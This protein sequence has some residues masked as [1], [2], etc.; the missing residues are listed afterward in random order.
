MSGSRMIRCATLA[1]LV[2]AAGGACAQSGRPYKLDWTVPGQELVY[3]SCGCADSCW[4]AE[5]RTAERARRVVAA[6]RCDCEKLYFSDVKG[7]ERMVSETCAPL[8]DEG[9][10][11]R[12]AKRIKELQAQGSGE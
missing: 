12:I 6:L 10:M 4:V 9:K 1:A 3:R 5:V 7:V 8:N 2:L 11:D